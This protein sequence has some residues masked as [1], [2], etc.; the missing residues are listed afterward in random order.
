VAPAATL[1]HLGA[2]QTVSPSLNAGNT[3]LQRKSWTFVLL[4]LALPVAI[5]VWVRVIPIIE[6]LRLSLFEWNIIS[7]R[8]PFVGL[9]NFRELFEDPLFHE[10]LWNTSLIAFGVLALTIP[11]ALILAALIHHRAGSRLAPFYETAIFIPHVVSL[12]PAAMAW[13]WVFDA[14]LGPLNAALSWFGIPPQPWLFDPLLAVICVIVLCSWQALGYALLIFLVGLKNVPRSLHEAASLDGANGVQQF[15]YVSLPVLRP[16]TLYVCV[17]T[18]IA[19]FNV[20]GQV[21][22]L[23]SDTQGAPGHLVRVLVLDM[24]ENSFRNYRVGYAAAE[25]V[26]LLAIV[27]VLTAIQF[28][29][30]RE[31]SRV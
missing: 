12:V 29:L 9:D 27:L 30:L 16:I 15:W 11:L 17:V 8:K 7:P 21:F 31:R 25:A 24:I 22:V 23:A 4:A 20:Y 10:A 14:K 18:L 2:A 26:V 19:A 1:T 28:G 3:A 6:T 13:K 5:F